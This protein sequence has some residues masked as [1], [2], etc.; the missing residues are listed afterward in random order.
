M[1][2]S[3]TKPGTKAALVNRLQATS[4]QHFDIVEIESAAD[5]KKLISSLQRFSQ[6]HKQK[7]EV[8]LLR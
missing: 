7:V 1:L 5:I 6:N 3:S 2:L 8:L 4:I